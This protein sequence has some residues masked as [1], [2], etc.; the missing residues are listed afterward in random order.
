MINRSLI[1]LIGLLLPVSNLLHAQSSLALSSAVVPPGG[2][3]A[4]D[5]SLS[6]PPSNQPAAI[7]WTF[8]YPTA[9]VSSLS[10]AAGPS[11]SAAGKSI[12]CATG[13]N[14]YTCIA[15]GLNSN[16][17]SDGVVAT[18]SVTLSGNRFCR[19]RSPT[20]SQLHRRATRSPSPVPGASSAWSPASPPSRA[21]RKLSPPALP[22]PAL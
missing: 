10:V 2:A 14:S 18:L 12:S 17:I 19:S 4:L 6:S 1:L 5:L 16:A 9:S 22:A 20:V 3:T 11:L 21:S 15:W 7:E 8:S 13:V